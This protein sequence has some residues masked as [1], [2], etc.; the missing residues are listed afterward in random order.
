[1]VDSLY[2]SLFTAPAVSGIFRSAYCFAPRR[3]SVKPT[4]RDQGQ[5]RPKISRL[6]GLVFNSPV[7][8]AN[9]KNRSKILYFPSGLGG[10]PEFTIRSSSSFCESR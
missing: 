3:R 10:D 6:A 4:V 8:T 5:A 2:C 7:E 1:M 9:A